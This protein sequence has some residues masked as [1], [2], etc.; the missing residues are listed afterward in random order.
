MSK[1]VFMDRDG[2]IIKEVGYLSNQ[3]E[4]EFFP[5]SVAALKRLSCSEYKLVVVTNQSGVGRGMF[6]EKTL[7]VIH[8]KIR[9]MLEKE[10]VELD[11]I[12]YC[13]HHPDDGCPCR[14]PGTALLE[15]AMKELDISS[16]G[17]YFIGDATSDIECGRKIGLTTI[18][19]ET[20]YAGR[21]GRYS[22]QPDFVASDLLAAAEIILGEKQKQGQDAQ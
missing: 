16:K 3:D 1:A 20:G 10:G 21:D 13:P 11:G 17:S 22:V 12:Y 7:N 8:D 5:N 19:V 4:I 9:F 2:V 14:K 18:L 15:K 6:T